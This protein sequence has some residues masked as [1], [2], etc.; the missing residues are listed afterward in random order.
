MTVSCPHVSGENTVTENPTFQ[1]RSLEY[2]K[3]FESAV[4]LYSFGWEI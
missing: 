2:M 1:K 3:I 4:L